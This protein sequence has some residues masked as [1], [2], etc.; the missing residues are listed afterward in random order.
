MSADKRRKQQLQRILAAKVIVRGVKRWLAVRAEVREWRR[1]R[2]GVR[3]IQRAWRGWV[4]SKKIRIL[5]KFRQRMSAV[6]NGWKIR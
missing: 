3:G 1:V 4:L 2:A 5:S 6:V